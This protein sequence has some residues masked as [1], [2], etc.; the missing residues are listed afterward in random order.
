MRDA[1]G[2]G[3]VRRGNQAARREVEGSRRRCVPRRT[4]LRRPGSS[5]RGD[6]LV[7]PGGADARHRR[8]AP[9]HSARAARGGEGEAV[10]DA[11]LDDRLAELVAGYGMIAPP[12]LERAYTFRNSKHST[13]GGALAALRLIKSDEL[14]KLL[15]E[16]TGVRSVDP[17]LMTVHDSFIERMN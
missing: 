9:R 6:C 10:P 16:L 8:P 4:T 14:Q 7:R 15:Q 3:P 1:A 5:A 2:L 11:E 12:V 13:L 17:S